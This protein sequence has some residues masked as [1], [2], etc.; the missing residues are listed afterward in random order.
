MK[1]ASGQR[2]AK[3]LAKR[4][5]W[6]V[7]LATIGK[8]LRSRW[9]ERRGPAPSTS[10]STHQA[11]SLSESLAYIDAVFE[12]Y[13]GHGALSPADLMGTRALE[14]GPG[15]NYGVALR[16]LASGVQRVVCVDRFDSVRDPLQQR[17][18]YDALLD[19]L[20]EGERI[21][22]EKAI[23]IGD[24]IRFDVER[25][26]AI[27]GLGI[28]EAGSV[29]DRA[30][31]D[32]I[33]S[34]AVLEHLED[35]DAAFAAMDRLLA[36]GG[37]MLHKVDFRD[38]GMFTGG[39]LHPLTFLTVRERPYGWMTRQSGR[40][41]R[42]LVDWYRA[43]LDELAYDW[44]ILVTHVLGDDQDLVPHQEDYRL[45]PNDDR[46]TL[47]L[48]ESI[49]PRLSAAFRD[50]S[51]DDL[52]VTGVFIVARKTPDEKPS[53]GHARSAHVGRPGVETRAQ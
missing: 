53:T 33:V 43:K 22:A 26:R 3:G 32:L 46:P 6:L 25:L 12:D 35:P 14:L 34:R 8:N 11:L 29:L 17:K 45:D 40:P 48:I 37:L 39:G 27:E 44:R 16:F 21:R 31:F 4:S 7:V 9:A 38:H 51:D 36:P 28:E 2:R 23:E 15:D 52:A 49:R 30:S 20:G 42:R 10:G 47:E 24:E 1:S 18:I 41:N 5:K 50:L 19:R 13:L